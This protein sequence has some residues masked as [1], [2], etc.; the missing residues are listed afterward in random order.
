MLLQSVLDI[1]EE[2]FLAAPYISEKGMHGSAA[3]SLVVSFN[4]D[5]LVHIQECLPNSLSMLSKHI[6]MYLSFYVIALQTCRR[7]NFR[8][9]ATS[10]AML[11]CRMMTLCNNNYTSSLLLRKHGR[12]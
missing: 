12:S 6:R 9:N 8:F 11:H 10:A 3:A 2:L 4:H 1:F 7:C 5:L